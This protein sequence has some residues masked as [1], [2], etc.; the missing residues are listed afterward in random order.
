MSSERKDF[1]FEL[2]ETLYFERGDEVLELIG[3]SLNPEITIQS[4]DTY[5]SLQGEIE[6]RGEYI[7][8]AAAI[9]EDEP[10]SLDDIG[11]KRYVEQVE[12]RANNIA[13][14]KHSFPVEI[15]IPDYR[16]ENMDDIRIDIINFDYEFPTNSNIQLTAVAEI[17]GIKGEV[18]LWRDRQAESD[19]EQNDEDDVQSF[20][21]EVERE[22]SDH[23]VHAA[24]QE[25][26]VEQDVEESEAVVEVRASAESSDSETETEED[27]S[28]EN[29]LTIRAMDEG[30]EEKEIRDVSYL[31]DIFRDEGEETYT[32]MK[33]CI[34]QENDTIESI[35]ERFQI[36]TLQLIKSNKLD[37]DFEINEGQLLY[38]PQK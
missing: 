14:F 37:D 24:E 35:A 8:D 1:Q 23:E 11:A 13:E 4:Y 36:S 15:S 7:I 17:Q 33:I 38:I 2:N 32:R 20:S 22:E 5:V 31:A 27:E 6:L 29:E 21:F 26:R 12:H 25:T 34:V 19:E 10:L 28:T 18:D 9:G 16:I 3:I 30:E